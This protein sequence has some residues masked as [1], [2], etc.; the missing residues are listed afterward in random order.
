MLLLGG[1]SANRERLERARF[2]V[3]ESPGEAAGAAVA[4]VST[5]LPR[6]KTTRDRA[7]PAA[8]EQRPDPPLADSGELTRIA[9]LRVEGWNQMRCRLATDGEAIPLEARIVG[10]VDRIEHLHWQGP[11]NAEVAAQLSAEANSACDPTL[12]EVG[13]ELLGLA[14]DH[15]Q[16]SDIAV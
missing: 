10:L 6:G 7:S 2:E 11:S 4:L 13:L 5:R 15:E 1:S 8:R 12:V 14:E 16:P 3:S 9:F